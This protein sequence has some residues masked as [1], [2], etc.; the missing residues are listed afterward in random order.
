MYQ[1]HGVVGLFLEGDYAEGGGGENA[2]L[3]SYVMAR[4]LW[5]PNDDVNG[6][7]AE[8][9]AAYYGQAAKAMRAYFD[10]L[11]Q[12]VRPAPGGKGYHMWIGTNPGAPYLSED[13]LTRAMELFREAQ[14][15]A[16]DEVLR[17]RVRK[18]RLSID[19]VNFMHAKTFTVRDGWY[20]PAHIDELKENFRSF[21]TDVRSFGIT[22]L[23]EG[24]KLAQEEERFAKD[25]KPYRVVTLE[26]S[27]LRVVV[28]PQLDGRIIHMIEKAAGKDVLHLPDSGEREWRE[29]NFYPNVAGLSVGVYSDYATT[30][31]KA[32]WVVASQP[33]PQEL[34][35]AATYPNGLR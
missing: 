28:V 14:T 25:V 17:A 7:I 4:L 2:E 26:N 22:E 3:R 31:Y 18:A 13:F 32:D 21:M 20:A 5:N 9:M 19:Y 24:I 34:F 29:R 23:H 16:K 8:F 35:L 33:G 10:L 12:Q 6:I 1:K 15:A 11:H 27:K 30:N